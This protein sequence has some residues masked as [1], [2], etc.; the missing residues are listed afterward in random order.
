MTTPQ[1]EHERRDRP[2]YESPRIAVLGTLHEITLACTNK[3][4][5]G[6]DGYTFQQ[7]PIQWSC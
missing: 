2:A 4:L 6:S 7:S 5:G 3:E 1:T